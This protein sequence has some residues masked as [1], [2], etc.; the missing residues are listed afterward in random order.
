[1]PGQRWEIPFESLPDTL[2]VFPLPGV[3]LLPGTQ[4]PLNIF[5]P[6]YLNMITDALGAG[7]LI[8][9]I[10][11]DPGAAPAAEP[12]PL[13]RVGCAGRISSFSETD[14]GRLLIVLTGVCR[15]SV[16]EELVTVRGYRRVVADWQGFQGDY[17]PALRDFDRPAFLQMLR[18]FFRAR[19]IEVDWEAMDQLE[20]WRLVNVL[21]GTLPFDAVDRQALLEAPDSHDR[22][23]LLAALVQIALAAQH[24][25]SAMRH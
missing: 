16:R 21:A 20:S 7:R 24:E 23:Q 6:R 4:V 15:F 11:P 22:A 2:G 5:E 8:G 9:L 17:S 1:M 10:Q 13:C 19:R 12:P 14:D 3:L 18:G 25:S